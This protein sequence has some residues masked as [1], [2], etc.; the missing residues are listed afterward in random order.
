[1]EAAFTA[2]HLL[3][4][5]RFPTRFVTGRSSP[6]RA[7][8]DEKAPLT[9]WNVPLGLGLLFV[10]CKLKAASAICRSLRML[11]DPP[12]APSNVRVSNPIAHNSDSFPDSHW[13]L[14]LGDFSS[15]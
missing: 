13:P 5:H 7:C 6:A 1:M 11:P 10:A 12:A 15:A 4:R 3:L 9:L 8:S 2:C 14:A